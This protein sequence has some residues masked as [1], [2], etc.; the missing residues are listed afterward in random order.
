MN[1]INMLD[2][3]DGLASGIVMIAS[4]SLALIDLPYPAGILHHL[5][6]RARN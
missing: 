5:C 1:A 3:L 6:G 4:I 2:G